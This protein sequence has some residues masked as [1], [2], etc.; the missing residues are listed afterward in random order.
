[1]VED[2]QDPVGP[3]LVESGVEVIDGVTQYDAR[4]SRTWR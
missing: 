3:S 4:A 1:M 2:L